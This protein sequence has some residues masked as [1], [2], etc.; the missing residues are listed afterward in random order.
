[1]E[2]EGGRDVIIPTFPEQR[3]TRVVCLRLADICSVSAASHERETRF[4]F[5][6][7]PSHPDLGFNL[8]VCIFRQT[9]SRQ[10]EVSALDSPS[11]TDFHGRRH[12]ERK[13]FSTGSL[14]SVLCQRY[15][16]R[17]RPPL[18]FMLRTLHFNFPHARRNI[19]AR[20]LF[21]SVR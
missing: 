18:R 7:S 6:T 1:M 19:F 12:C 2:G 20:W 9:R 3:T 5:T 8:S 16:A 11:P 10:T 4:Y 17:S 13:T 15:A 21:L 14:C